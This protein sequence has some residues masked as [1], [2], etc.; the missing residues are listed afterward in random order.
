MQKGFVFIREV[1]FKTAFK[2]VRDSKE[3]LRSCNDLGY[4]FHGEGLLVDSFATTILSGFPRLFYPF[5]G[6]FG[7][8]STVKLLRKIQ[9]FNLRGCPKS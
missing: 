4:S 6:G 8:G 5:R 1:F 2:I 9:H 3:R 7:T